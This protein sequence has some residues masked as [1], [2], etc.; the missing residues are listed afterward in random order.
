MGEAGCDP[1]AVPVV[2]SLVLQVA[3]DQLDSLSQNIPMLNRHKFQIVLVSV[4]LSNNEYK[5]PVLS[6]ALLLLRDVYDIPVM[7]YSSVPV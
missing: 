3:A 7:C 4:K 1:S 5:S 2:H 6:L